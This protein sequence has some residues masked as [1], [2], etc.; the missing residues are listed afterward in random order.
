M[1]FN[2]RSLFHAAG[3]EIPDLFAVGFLVA[4][5]LWRWRRRVTERDVLPLLI[6]TALLFG[7]AHGYDVAALSLLIPAFWRHLH[8]RPVAGL[9]ALGLLVAIAF[10]NS[11][12]ERFGSEL[13]LHARVALTAGA[14]VWLV[15]LSAAEAVP[16][17]AAGVP[18][19]AGGPAAREARQA[20]EAS[21][22][23][24]FPSTSR[25]P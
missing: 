16:A 11:L 6:G 10:P 5:A 7:F 25:I 14:L 9:A 2:L 18:A 15:A 12:L 8:R 22:A 19:A 3:I 24:C 17:A 20:G 23:R 4:A 21:L 13:L 1:L